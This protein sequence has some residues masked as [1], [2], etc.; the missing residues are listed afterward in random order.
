MMRI[1]F[2]ILTAAFVLGAVFLDAFAPNAQADDAPL[3]W[4]HQ[5][6]DEGVEVRFT[7]HQELTQI[8]VLATNQRTKRSATFKKPALQ[9]GETWTVRLRKPD[10]TTDYRI[11]LRGQVGTQTF[12]GYYT[13]TI[14]ADTPPDFT[15]PYTRFEGTENVLHLVPDKAI[16]RVHVRARGKNGMALADFER[17]INAPANTTVKLTFNTPSAILD[18]D[19]TMTTA[20]GASR[21]YRYTPWSFRTESRNLNFETG[22]ATIHPSDLNKLTQV[23]EEIQQVVNDVG[24]YTDLQLYLAGYTDTVGS[25]RT[26]EALSRRRALS[27]AQFMKER[28]VSIPIYIQGFGERVLAVPTADDVDEPANRR[29]IFILRA[30]PPPIEPTFPEARWERIR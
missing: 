29:A 14:D 17:V 16:E 24:K 22:S 18:V 3:A 23:Y 6:T 30:N 8:Q 12:E 5:L 7:A 2:L 4:S 20:N 1:P 28:G 11:D 19:V 10:R 27:I 25:E 13:F 9:L 21:S 15:A 26:N